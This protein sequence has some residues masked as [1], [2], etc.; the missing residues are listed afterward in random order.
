MANSP[1]PL[2]VALIASPTGPF[3][4]IMLELERLLFEQ[5]QVQMTRFDVP[6]LFIE[7]IWQMDQAVPHL[8]L[9]EAEPQTAQDGELLEINPGLNCLEQVR[10]LESGRLLPIVMLAGQWTSEMLSNARTHQAASCLHVPIDPSTRLE[11]FTALVTYWCVVNE[12]L[13]E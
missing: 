9:L 6:E 11:V 4:P 3:A 5:D 2:R 1:E 8:A 12:P 7:S 13:Q 10:E